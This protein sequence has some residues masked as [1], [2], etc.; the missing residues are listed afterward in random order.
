VNISNGIFSTNVRATFGSGK[1]SRLSSCDNTN[2]FPDPPDDLKNKRKDFRACFGSAIA[3]DVP[4]NERDQK[5][6]LRVAS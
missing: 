6:V 3:K 1:I 5:V 4:P 2:A